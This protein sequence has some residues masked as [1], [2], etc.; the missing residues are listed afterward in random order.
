MRLE[1]LHSA[2]SDGADCN[3]DTSSMWL[4]K[5]L[6]HRIGQLSGQTTPKIGGMFGRTGSRP[7]GPEGLNLHTS[8]VS[9]FFPPVVPS[10]I[11]IIIQVCRFL[12]KRRHF[13][14]SALFFCR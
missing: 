11:I 2:F 6:H 10:F 4:F 13:P 1:K 5:S 8:G 7:R 12:Y 14:E 3:K 9:L